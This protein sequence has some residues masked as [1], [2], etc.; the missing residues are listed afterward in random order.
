[1]RKIFFVK[2]ECSFVDGCLRLLQVGLRALHDFFHRQVGGE[3]ETQFLS[4]LLRAEAEIAVGARQ[5]IFLKP[6]FV[7]FEC[8]CGFF[9]QPCK[10]LFHLRHAVE[11]RSESFAHETNG[12]LRLLDCRFRMDTWRML[13]IGFCLCDHAW[14]SLH[15]LTQAR[16]AFF[17][18]SEV[19]R[20][21]KIKAVRQALVVNERI[22]IWF[23]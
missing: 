3:R 7:V 16:N 12:A 23:F 5:Q 9:L 15:T 1:M 17:R 14:N 19:A 2:R 21:Q 18:G 10:F 4:K 22:P 13:E 6:F 8:R 11:E 20:N